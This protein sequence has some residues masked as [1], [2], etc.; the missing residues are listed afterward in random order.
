MAAS[1]QAAAAYAY[2]DPVHCW[3]AVRSRAFSVASPKARGAP[4]YLY[5]G[6]WKRLALIVS[7]VFLFAAKK[8]IRTVETSTVRGIANHEGMSTALDPLL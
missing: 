1:F 6:P 8:P 4:E 3:F 5:N 2:D 7:E